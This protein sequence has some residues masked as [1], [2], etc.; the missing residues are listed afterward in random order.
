MVLGDHGRRILA[1]ATP[2][3]QAVAFPWKRFYNHSL[4]FRML[5]RCGVATIAAWTYVH[6]K[7]N[8]TSNQPISLNRPIL[9]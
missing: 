3:Q 5:C 6:M 9:N 2:I 8:L 7:G 4:Y 1:P